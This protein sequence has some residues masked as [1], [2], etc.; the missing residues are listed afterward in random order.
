MILLAL[1]V[2][3]D[4]TTGLQG[5]GPVTAME[6]LA[7]F[8][9]SS[10]SNF[11]LSHNQ[12]LMGLTEFKSWFTSGKSI[13]RTKNSLR[14]KL[15]NV[16]FIDGFPS[17]QVVQ[18]YLN[19]TID[20]SKEE[21]SWSKPDLVSLIDFGRSKF[22][23]SKEKTQNLL[24]PVMK[25][26]KES[27]YQK[28]LLN[29]FKI[30][31]DL[32]AEQAQKL[33]SERVRSAVK[34]IGQDPKDIEESDES[35]KE[36][37]KNKKKKGDE[38]GTKVSAVKQKTKKKIKDVKEL[39]SDD[40]LIE[41]DQIE[42]LLET[43]EKDKSKKGRKKKVV[44]PS[45]LLEK[46]ESEG[47]MQTRECESSEEKSMENIETLKKEDPIPLLE[48]NEMNLLIKVLSNQEP[49]TSENAAKIAKVRKIA[50]KIER[51]KNPELKEQELAVVPKK[52]KSKKIGDDNI[53]E[54]PS[55]SKRES[56]VMKLQRI[57]KKLE[58]KNVEKS[59]VKKPLKKKKI[60]ATTSKT[61]DNVEKEL[62]LLKETKTFSEKHAKELEDET[63]KMLEFEL[64][65]KTLIERKLHRKEI[66][67]Q[68]ER[69]QKN[70]MNT[71]LKAI[72]VFRKSKID[73][74]SKKVGTHKIRPPKHE[75]ELSESSSD[76]D[77]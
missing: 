2:G 58:G 4:Y 10:T 48:N 63:K 3:S 45:K 32:N 59:E 55:P 14:N 70:L 74:S 47:S 34:R 68:R 73:P 37:K 77:L 40:E 36:I 71:R 53:T 27:K 42:K 35:D 52:K 38:D 61:T 29:Y 8:P 76:S 28:T 9:P 26:M 12:L 18:A 16:T 30:K 66:I 5:V 64:K 54:E 1:L 39:L 22:G 56:N 33:M 65:K 44:K 11:T 19:P 7:N 50:K 25:R 72:E 41:L 62:K 57:V 46:T 49:C 69:S 43:V 24:D 67:P 23:W 17:M 60:E 13:A 51:V 75:A 6:I 15:K 21:F 20:Q 31:H